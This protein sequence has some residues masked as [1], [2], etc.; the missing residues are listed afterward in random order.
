MKWT[1]RWQDW[2]QICSQPEIY[3]EE[4]LENRDL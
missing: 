4:R 2:G 3:F 1:G